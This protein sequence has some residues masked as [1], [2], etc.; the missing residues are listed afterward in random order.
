MEIEST[1]FIDDGHHAMHTLPLYLSRD[2][3]APN[4]PSQRRR[5]DELLVLVPANRGH[6]GAETGHPLRAG[7]VDPG[8]GARPAGGCQ[9]LALWLIVLD[10]FGSKQMLHSLLQMEKQLASDKQLLTRLLKDISM[11]AGLVA[12]GDNIRMTKKR[13]LDS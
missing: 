7:Q 9:H 1:D 8:P 10:L 5:P 11:E 2:N 3:H 13:S 12:Y 4:D 6:S